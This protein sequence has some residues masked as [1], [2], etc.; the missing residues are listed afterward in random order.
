VDAHDVQVAQALPEVNPVTDMPTVEQAPELATDGI[1]GGVVHVVVEH[2]ELHP[3][4]L[5]L[6]CVLEHQG[7]G[8]ADWHHG[9]EGIDSLVRGEVGVAVRHTLDVAYHLKVAELKDFV[10]Y[11]HVITSCQILWRT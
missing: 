2:R 9:D 5:H 8:R 10:G 6:G 11:Q 4:L 7:V 3:D 1:N